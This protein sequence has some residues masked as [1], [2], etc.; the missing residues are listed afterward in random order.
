MPN[1]YGQWA[2]AIEEAQNRQREWYKHQ[3]QK[4]KEFDNAVKN[5][6]SDAEVS[7]LR[8]E[9]KS[10]QDTIDNY[11]QSNLELIHTVH[12]LGYDHKPIKKQFL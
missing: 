1:D 12:D 8:N 9:L 5:N 11:F 6:A 2:G 3:T 7:R 10:I 4:E